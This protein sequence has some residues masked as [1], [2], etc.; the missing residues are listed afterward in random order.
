MNR[1]TKTCFR[2]DFMTP[3]FALRH[4]ALAAV[5]MVP[6]LTT[7]QAKPFMVVGND[8]KMGWDDQGKAVLS[9]PGKDT[10]SIIDLADPAH[11]KITANL[12]LENTI[13][14]PPTNV[15][16]TPSGGLALFANS[17][18]VASDNG[19]LKQ[20]PADQLYVLDLTANPPK[21]VATVTVGKQ[22]SGLDINAK[23]DMALIGNRA[24]KSVTVLSI[25]G[26][27]VKV[28]D[29]IQF[30]DS[31]AHVA[32]TPDGHHAVVVRNTVNLVS[33]LDI[34]ADGKVTY[35]NV[36]L[37][38]GIWPYNAVVTLDSKLALVV[39]QGKGGACDGNLEAVTVIDL[40]AQPSHVI[41]QV[42]VG[43]CPEGLAVSPKGDIAIA[44]LLRGSNVAKTAPY[45]HKNGSVAVMK[46]TGKKVTMIKEIEVG[47]LPEPIAFSPDGNFV[48]V[49]NFQDGDLA[50][51]QVKGAQVTDTG[52]KLKLPGHPASGRSGP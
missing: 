39:N 17:I 49:G 31:V 20:V 25:R 45:Y 50:I 48:Y 36:D 8:E 11:P 41:D 23:G 21:Q 42:T 34:G 51:L 46:I 5:L 14:G 15:A 12:Q 33:L 13:V 30:P 7:A 37:P 6:V 29:T 38:T 22:P 52:R 35:N 18:D 4:I 19:A 32:F 44:T 9:L 1:S 2:E 43:D 26:T 16:I 47:G 3:A 24:D 28:V 40:A 27:E 10:I